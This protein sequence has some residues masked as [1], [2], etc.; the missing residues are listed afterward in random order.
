MG[1]YRR[2]LR[3][4]KANWL[5]YLALFFLVALCMYVVVGLVAAADTVVQTVNTST[6]ENKREDGQFTVFVPLTASQLKELEAMG[7]TVEPMPYLD[8]TLENGSV[9]RVFK[10]RESIN[11][12]QADE[13]TLP[14]GPGEVLLEKLYAG[15]HGLRAGETIA[16][17]GLTLLVC[18]AGTTPDYDLPLQNL[19]DVAANKQQFGTAFVSATTYAELKA[20]GRSGKSEEYLYAYRLNGKL[21]H[22]ELKERLKTFTAA[23]EDITDRFFLEMLDKLETPK[24]RF[25]NS[26]ATLVQGGTSLN[27]ALTEL[28]A[29]G[30]DLGAALQ[31][32]GLPPQL[33]AAF[34]AYL[35]GVQAA[36]DGA[37]NLQK[38]LE[39]LWKQVEELADELFGFTIENLTSF[40]K[41]ENN[42]RIAASADD[43]AINKTG[44]I[45]AGI[46]A[47][48][49]FAYVISVFVV[50]TVN[51][52]SEVIGT[53]YA[54]GAPKA[55]LLR[56]Y[57]SL[58]VLVTA[59]G[60][61]CGTALGFSA[62][63]VSYQMQ[64]T[65]SYFSYPAPQAIY[66]VYLLVYGLVLPPVITALVNWLVVGKRLARS[67]LQLLRK[68]QST[69]K[70]SRVKLRK[71]TFIGMFR[72]RQ[73]LRE[74]RAA[75][76]VC[77]GMFIALLLLVLGLNCYSFI[78]TMQ[79]QNQQDIQYD[80][81]ISLK[82]P[83]E[84]MPAG[85]TAC[86]MQT[87]TRETYGYEMD[88]SLLGIDAANP[89]FDF[90]P[91]KGTGMLT[92]SSSM[93]NKFHLKAGDMVYLTDGIEEK[94]YVFTVD[95]VV[96]YGVGLY[97]FMDIGSM[98]ELFGVAED[99]YNT[100]LAGTMPNLEAGRIYAVT[101]KADILEYG[102][103]FMELMTPLIVM[104][105]T[106]GSVV[107]VIVLY[108]MMKMM[109]DRSAFGISLM[110]IFGYNNTEVRKLYLDGNFVTVA[111]AAIVGVPLAKL[112][113]NAVYP[114]LIANVA[115]GPELAMPFWIYAAIYGLILVSY[116]CISLLLG[117]RLK[118]VTPAEVLKRR[119]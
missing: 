93:A 74:K 58:P 29:S 112:V 66:P 104:L 38:G 56:H 92:I 48:A 22:S 94:N 4:L 81:M 41:A 54:M 31:Q 80:Y 24:N 64:D 47:L 1:L 3:E 18:G 106:V 53:L 13:G 75:F 30:E 65:A 68:G 20:G 57:L 102:Q 45:F 25:L 70:A 114:Y 103:I 98:R 85:T 43:V 19:T 91:A 7:A 117:R 23:R 63:G 97:A 105:V 34:A 83:P 73:I 72:I 77:G 40:V 2:I 79:S 113:M 86:Y 61:V 60:G 6:E 46:V 32:M 49:L 82:Y 36:A 101:S 42:P 78:T 88:I 28:S 62:L 37:N 109:V 110:K 118:R 108:L 44:G 95:K 116:L 11:L 89:Y 59:L 51:E 115:M 55:A 9:L 119:E 17:G 10:Q 21:T 39:E 111:L 69:A 76:A 96:P 33:A 8:F 15:A 14:G 107:F 84:E 35:D 52:E 67:P 5:R 87:L 27:G 50:H 12:A 16:L 100:L 90:S 26:V 71:L 99:A